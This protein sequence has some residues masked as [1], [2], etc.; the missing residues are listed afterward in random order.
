MDLVAFIIL[1]Y[2][3]A[4][5]TIK[6]VDGLSKYTGSLFDFQIIVVDNCSPDKSLE[7]LHEYYD[8]NERIDI[9]SSQRNGGYSYGN[10]FGVRY[11][12]QK[13]NP[14]F[15][16]IANP[17][18]WVDEATVKNLLE[19][20]K[21]DEKLCMCSP[22]MK[23][24]HGKG[25]IYSQT[26]PTYKDDLVACFYERNS[27]TIK[28]SKFD[29]LNG[30]Q[31]MILTEMLPGSFFVTRTDL[32]QEIG[33]LDENVFL[34][35]EE[36]ILGRRM[37]EC[38]YKAVLRADLSF[39]HKHSTS[40]NKAY[41]TIQTRKLILKSRIYYEENY[42]GINSMQSFILKEASFISLVYLRLKLWLRKLIKG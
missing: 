3:D 34:F 12:I 4:D 41:K 29:Y 2:N 37:K 31:N 7:K 19:T 28:T 5:T 25:R 24:V 9:I 27:K 15:L 33:M 20:F 39:L 22:V 38:G 40:I 17:D 10:N 32:F 14:E 35:C 8:A 13:Y 42:N 1:N 30:N 36:R 16:V 21:E 18:I 6:L 11:A 23:D 26:L